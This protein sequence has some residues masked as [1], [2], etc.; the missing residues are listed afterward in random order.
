[1]NGFETEY[2]AV[3]FRC[4]ICKDLIGYVAEG[5]QEKFYRIF[6]AMMIVIVY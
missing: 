1:M 4:T 2:K 3:Y 5:P 6:K